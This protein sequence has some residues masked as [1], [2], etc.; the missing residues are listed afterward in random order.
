MALTRAL[1][2]FRVDGFDR[3]GGAETH[4]H[5]RANQFASGHRSR[6]RMNCG[7]SLV[8]DLLTPQNPRQRSKCLSVV[9]GFPSASLLTSLIWKS[10]L[11]EPSAAPPHPFIPA[12][13][14]IHT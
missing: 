2:R 14:P 4:L 1:S 12:S 3:D 9:T 13:P 10:Q 6:L 8:Q 5:L 7:R 11:P